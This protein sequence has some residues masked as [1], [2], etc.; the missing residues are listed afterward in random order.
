M[1]THVRIVAVI[2]I[3]FGA[4]FLLVGG[5]II[6]LLVGIGF[7]SGD[8]EA[9]TV[10]SII[11]AAFG[12]L[13]LVVSIPGIIGGFGLLQKKEWARILVL[14]ISVI[15]L[16]NIPIGTVVGAYSLYVLLQQ[17]TMEMFNPVPATPVEETA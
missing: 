7:L 13:M 15:D 12:L 6:L 2:N 5:G 16:I 1:E 14:I 8:P 4:L 3:V 11:G 10:L 17:E 9:M